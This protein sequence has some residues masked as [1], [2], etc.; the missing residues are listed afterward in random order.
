MEDKTRH[1]KGG[2]MERVAFLGKPYGES[3]LSTRPGNM[4][5]RQQD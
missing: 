2:K 1:T 3:L 4:A 5:T